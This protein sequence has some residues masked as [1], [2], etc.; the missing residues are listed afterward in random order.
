MT[1]LISIAPAV[2]R[3]FI[4]NIAWPCREDLSGKIESTYRV[5]TENPD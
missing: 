5:N 4:C 1:K 3:F 2:S